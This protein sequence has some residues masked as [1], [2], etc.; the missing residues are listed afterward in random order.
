MNELKQQN[1]GAKMMAKQIRASIEQNTGAFGNKDAQ[2]IVDY[3]RELEHTV[4]LLNGDLSSI[5]KTGS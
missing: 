3:V 1:F 5:K 2:W 4:Q